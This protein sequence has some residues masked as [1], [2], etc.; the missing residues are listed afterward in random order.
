[1]GTRDQ[2]IR[3]DIKVLTSRRRTASAYVFQVRD[4]ISPNNNTLHDVREFA[5]RILKIE[6]ALNMHAK[7]LRSLIVCKVADKGWSAKK[8]KTI[9]SNIVSGSPDNDVRQTSHVSQSLPD[10]GQSVSLEK[11]NTDL[12][13]LQRQI[14]K[15]AIESASRSTNIESKVDENSAVCSELK[16]ATLQIVSLQ[17]TINSKIEAD[18]ETSRADRETS[19]ETHRLL[20]ATQNSIQAAYQHEY[21]SKQNRLTQTRSYEQART[22]QL[23]SVNKT[24]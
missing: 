3:Q 15:N 17:K 16:R 23:L 21:G 10:N 9:L 19:R 24:Q 2:A 4:L 8:V 11:H 20:Q 22:T 18:R 12:A 5:R 13:N 6:N 14:D 7:A 1:M